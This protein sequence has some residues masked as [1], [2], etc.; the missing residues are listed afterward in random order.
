ML[1]RRL[2]AGLSAAGVIVVVFWAGGIQR[3]SN[4]ATEIN[5]RIRQFNESITSDV[6]EN[7]SAVAMVDRIDR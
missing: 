2:A 4:E 5:P 1:G 6:V 7:D 3:A